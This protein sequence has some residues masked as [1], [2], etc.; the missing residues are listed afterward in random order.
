MNYGPKILVTTGEKIVILRD[1]VHIYLLLPQIYTI[2]DQISKITQV[3]MRK[4][5][6]HFSIGK[7]PRISQ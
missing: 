7:I 5:E 2:Q 4:A 1:Y 6:F 3:E